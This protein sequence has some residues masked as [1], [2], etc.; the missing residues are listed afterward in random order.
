MKI[1]R[2]KSK[3]N[4][5]DQHTVTEIKKAFDG[6]LSKLDTAEERISILRKSQQKE[7]KDFLKRGKKSI[8]KDYETSSKCVTYS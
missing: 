4:A 3:R 6:L 7:T 5:R 1:L 2:E 8:S